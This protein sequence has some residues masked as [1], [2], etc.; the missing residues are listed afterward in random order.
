MIQNQLNELSLDRSVKK[1][2]S[3]IGEFPRLNKELSN[4]LS[5]MKETFQRNSS[6]QGA[7]AAEMSKNY[8]R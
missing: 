5:E 8:I 6:D 1:T 7:Y 2:I 3:K 4:V